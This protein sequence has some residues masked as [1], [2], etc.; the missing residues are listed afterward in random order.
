MTAVSISI[1][2]FPSV[3][4]FP[5][6]CAQFHSISDE[7][8]AYEM[9][10]EGEDKNAGHRDGIV[11]SEGSKDICPVIDQVVGLSLPLEA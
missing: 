7:K 11:G 10:A 5:P 8:N 6:W 1:G 3:T 4:P 9:S 2:T